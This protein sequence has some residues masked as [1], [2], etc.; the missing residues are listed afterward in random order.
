MSIP[1]EIL[2]HC[3]SRSHAVPSCGTIVKN[4]RPPTK[5][6][7]ETKKKKQNQ[8][9]K[10]NESLLSAPGTWL[11]SSTKSC[12]PLLVGVSVLVVAT[13][14]GTGAAATHQCNNNSFQWPL[15]DVQR[16]ENKINNCLTQFFFL[17]FLLT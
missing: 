8:S 13:A 1:S 3:A 7:R 16:N 12:R 14:A 9:C 15:N 17:L 11:L 6:N 2:L 5:Y 4:C 10:L